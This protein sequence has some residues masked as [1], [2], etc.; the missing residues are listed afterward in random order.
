MGSFAGFGD[1]LGL[2]VRLLLWS[3]RLE[4]LAVVGSVLQ[5]QIRLMGWL[6][7]VGANFCGSCNWNTVVVYCWGFVVYFADSVLLL[8]GLFGCLGSLSSFTSKLCFILLLRYDSCIVDNSYRWFSDSSADN[9]D[10]IASD[11]DLLKYF[12]FLIICSNFLRLLLIMICSNVLE[13]FCFL[14]LSVGMPI[15]FLVVWRF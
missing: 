5:L 2:T 1:C 6:L 14:E 11:D 3:I 12:Y 4:G 8:T 10:S 13:L 9:V 15:R 7:N